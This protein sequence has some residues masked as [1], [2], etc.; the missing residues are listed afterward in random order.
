VYIL[1]EDYVATVKLVREELRNRG[2]SDERN[3]IVGPGTS[4]PIAAK[5]YIEA[6]GME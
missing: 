1:P 2:I 5:P 3:G 6:F 4:G